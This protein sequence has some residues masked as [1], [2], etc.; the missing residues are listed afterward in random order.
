ML[1]LIAAVSSIRLGLVLVA[2][3][4]I[5]ED[6]GRYHTYGVPLVDFLFRPGHG[7]GVTTTLV[8]ALVGSSTHALV[9]AQTLIAVVL[10][11][12]AA[13]RALGTD[14]RWLPAVAVLVVSLSPWVLV[15]DAWPITEPIGLAALGLL[16]V[17]LGCRGSAW[18]VAGPAMLAVLTKPALL[19]LVVALVAVEWLVSRRKVM[20]VA[21]AALVASTVFVAWDAYRFESAP[22]TADHSR[23]SMAAARA[24]SRAVTRMDVVPGYR[25]MALDAGMPECGPASFKRT[26]GGVPDFAQCPE[27]TEWLDKG[28][29]SWVKELTGNP[30]ATLTHIASPGWWLNE[31]MH[32]YEL[33][34][35]R[36]YRIFDIVGIGTSRQVV[37]L[38]VFGLVC[39]SVAFSVM[40]S[41]RRLVPLMF[42]TLCLGYVTWVCLDDGMEYWRHALGGWMVLALLASSGLARIGAPSSGSGELDPSPHS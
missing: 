33:L 21:L 42:V 4:V 26:H 40:R 16:V 38:A 17:G 29:L 34:D 27:L 36:T 39:L 1:A 10:W 2:D 19:P 7:P 41:R 25:Q 9:V 8:S 18:W 35:G 22:S 3:P 6:A 12:V 30:V 24:A 37:N 32:P 31:S 23:L 5:T 11:G 14:R 20:S 13:W 15:W 28:G